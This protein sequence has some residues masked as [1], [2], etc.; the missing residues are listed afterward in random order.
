MGV[1]T[2]TMLCGYPPFTGD[3]NN[4][5]YKKILNSELVFNEGDWT[6]VSRE[7]M[8]FINRLIV[9][10]T[11]ER[12]SAFDALQHPWIL[13]AEKEPRYLCPSVLKRLRLFKQ[14][15][16]LKQEAMM[17]LI[18]NLGQTDL[19]LVEGTFRALDKKNTGEVLVKDLI[20]AFQECGYSNSAK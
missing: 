19:K 18:N 9:E 13:N 15:Q 11:K 4:E 17:V 20:K 14:P 5:I 7:A 6:E 3:T 2:Y 12:L 10:D 1:I 16:R 8:H